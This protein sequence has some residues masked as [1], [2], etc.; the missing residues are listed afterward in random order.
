MVHQYQLNGYNIHA[1]IQ[2]KISPLSPLHVDNL[3]EVIVNLIR[4]DKT[5]KVFRLRIKNNKSGFGHG[6]H[7]RLYRKSERTYNKSF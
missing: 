3:L 2:G 5:G 6:L 4:Q 1:K 7:D